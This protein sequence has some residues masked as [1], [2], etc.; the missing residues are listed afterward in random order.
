MRR[1]E[2]DHKAKIAWVMSGE[3]ALASFA[4]EEWGGAN[5]AQMAAETYIDERQE[6]P[7]ELRERIGALEERIEAL[8]LEAEGSAAIIMAERAEVLALRKRIAKA[9]A[10]AGQVQRVKDFRY[11]PNIGIELNRLEESL[12]AYREGSDT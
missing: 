3:T 11:D 8:E 12:A 4:F 10:L 9:D 7:W 6:D 1:I 5:K 2:M